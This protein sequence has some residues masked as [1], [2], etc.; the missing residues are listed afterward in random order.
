ME[1]YS[2]RNCFQGKAYDVV[3][4]GEEGG[5]SQSLH[6]ALLYGDE[7]HLIKQTTPMVLGSA[8]DHNDIPVGASPLFFSLDTL[9]NSLTHREA[10]L[11]VSELSCP[12]VTQWPLSD[13]GCLTLPTCFHSN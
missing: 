2:V 11:R 10:A 13:L 7:I 1:S 6:C 4:S 8:L 5:V 3:M 9:N 12:L